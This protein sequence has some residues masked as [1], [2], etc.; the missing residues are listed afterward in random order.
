MIKTIFGAA[1]VA[2]SLTAAVA[3]TTSPA[4]AWC[5][6]GSSYGYHY[7]ASYAP[8]YGYSH[9]YSHSYGYGGY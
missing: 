3:A 6:Y 9:S 7:H 8:S 2:L 5:G 4:A 1:L